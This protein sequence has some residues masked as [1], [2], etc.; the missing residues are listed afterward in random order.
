MRLAVT[1]RNWFRRGNDV[2]GQLLASGSRDDCGDRI[3]VDHD[4]VQC[5]MRPVSDPS[6]GCM[7]G[8]PLLDGLVELFLERIQSSGE[9]QIVPNLLPELID[10]CVEV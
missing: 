1:W 7:E 9:G 6:P 4:E 8:S 2:A 3:G 10:E 5:I